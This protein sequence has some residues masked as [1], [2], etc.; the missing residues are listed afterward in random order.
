MLILIRL[1]IGISM[2]LLLE[3]FVCGFVVLELWNCGIVGLW[4][5][6]IE[7]G[8]GSVKGLWW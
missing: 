1:L 6:V 5:C 8:K 3:H 4:V 2:R 7:V